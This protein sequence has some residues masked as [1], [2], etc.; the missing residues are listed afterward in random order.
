MIVITINLLKLTVPTEDPPIWMGIGVRM[1]GNKQML[2]RIIHTSTH[3]KIN[4]R[5]MK[6]TLS[7]ISVKED[8][9][10]KQVFRQAR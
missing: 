8:C 3:R 4:I 7:K 10:L 1:T 9:C 6:T 5:N 2:R